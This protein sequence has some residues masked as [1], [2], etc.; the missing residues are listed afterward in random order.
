MYFLGK[1]GWAGDLFCV[2]QLYELIDLAAF[3]FIDNLKDGKITRY[4]RFF[5]L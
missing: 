1:E 5:D 3:F 4:R 2:S